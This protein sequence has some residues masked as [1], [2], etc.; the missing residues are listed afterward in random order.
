MRTATRTTLSLAILTITGVIIVNFAK[1][2]LLGGFFKSN[3]VQL[4][5][6]ITALV[7][8]FVLVQLKT[9]ERSEKKAFEDAIIRLTKFLD[10]LEITL[11]EYTA[12]W[13]CKKTLDD[14]RSEWRNANVKFRT[15]E[16]Y[17][18]AIEKTKLAKK[19]TKEISDIRNAYRNCNHTFGD[20]VSCESDQMPDALDKDVEALKDKTFGFLVYLSLRQQN[21]KH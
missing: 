16:N 14:L 13:Q 4:L 20:F 17:L 18:A 7:V 21:G 5:P 3:F 2:E 10:E 6:S 19:Y 8:S 1:P 15:F 9:D 12:A 11:S